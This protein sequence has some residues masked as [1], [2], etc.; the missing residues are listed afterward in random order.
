MIKVIADYIYNHHISKLRKHYEK[1]AQNIT[2]NQQSFI[3]WPV[4]IA[5][6]LSYPAIYS[7]YTSPDSLESS[8]ITDLQNIGIG[9][10]STSLQDPQS[11][12]SN[13][14]S[15]KQLWLAPKSFDLYQNG[16]DIQSGALNKNFLLDALSLQNELLD[17]INQNEDSFAFI[18]SPF[19]YWDNDLQLLKSDKSPIRILQKGTVKM[20]S[21]GVSLSHNGLFSGV[22]KVNGLIKSAEAI[23][24]LIFYESRKHNERDAGKIWDS[25]LLK[26]KENST[27][28]NFLISNEG[29]NDHS[30]KTFLL[31]LTKMNS[32]DHFVL[33]TSYVLIGVYF[34]VSLSNL[35]S[36]RSR[37]GLLSAFV[38]ELTLAV[39][40][41][42]TLTTY[43]FQGVDFYQIP[44]QFLPFV[45]IVVGIE[46]MF[47]LV[48]TLS[49]TPGELSISYR[50]SKALSDCG[51]TSTL[52]VLCD[53]AI[54]AVIYP[55][56]VPNTKQFCIFASFALII[57]HT[58]HLTYFT[59]VLSIDTH[60]LE[61]DDLLNNDSNFQS[62]DDK[63]WFFSLFNTKRNTNLVASLTDDQCNVSFTSVKA[64][65]K[66]VIM[67]I[68]LPFSTTVTGTIVMILFLIGT[69]IRWTD[70]SLKFPLVGHPQSYIGTHPSP[71]SNEFSSHIQ[72]YAETQYDLL[73]FLDKKSFS[74]EIFKLLEKSNQ[75]DFSKV[76]ISVYNPTVALHGASNDPETSFQIPFNLNTTYKFDLYYILEFLT[77]LAFIL[78][79]ALMVLRSFAPESTTEP[80]EETKKQVAEKDHT[81]QSKILSGGHFLDI[82][83]I[84]TSRSPFIVSVGLDHKVLVWSPVSQPMPIP[85]QLPIGS[86]IWPITHVVLSDHGSYISVFSKSGAIQCYSRL[87]MTWIWKVEIE[88]L[89][90]SLPLEAFFRRK[91]IPAFLQ[92]KMAT[93]LMQG[94]RSTPSSRRNSMRS[95]ASPNLGP[96]MAFSNNSGLSKDLKELVIV[97][98]NGLIA[99]VSCEDGSLKT[100]KLSAS[101]LVSSAKLITP[102]VN[103]RLVSCTEDGKLMLSTAVNNKWKT[104]IVKVDEKKFNNPEAFLA[105][106][107]IQT[108][109]T[110]EN[111]QTYEEKVRLNLEFSKSTIAIVP[112][113]GF[114]VRTHGSCAEIIDVQTGILIK[115]FQIRQF[116][117]NT[118]KVFHDQPTHCRFCGSVSISSFTVVYTTESSSVNM[119]TFNVDHRA[120][121][122]ICLRVE[123]DPREI[124]CV[125]FDSVTEHVHELS[126]TEGWSTTDKNQIVGIRRKTE[127]EVKQSLDE[128]RMSTL[129]RRRSPY[130]QSHSDENVPRLHNLWEGWAMSADGNIEYYDIP[131]VGNSGGLLVNSIGQINRFG[132]KSI[133]V[134]FGNIMQVLYLGNDDLIYNDE[135]KGTNNEISGLSFINKRR[136]N[137][138]RA[139][140]LTST[141]FS[142]VDNIPGIS[143]LA[144]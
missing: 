4:S 27:D 61:L 137:M 68:K 40:S 106:T 31:K 56:V 28:I 73:C 12:D 81:F 32:I 85:S 5:F 135:D 116:K 45:V 59:A 82:I 1:L 139:D 18:H 143:E 129:R 11:I 53:L 43:F 102:R 51:I 90:N 54:L 67:R 133:V 124:R 65:L 99:T 52:I 77:S 48:T 120:K 44:L 20:N 47:R 22:V 93:A 29:P 57:D 83:K 107:N 128:A 10:Q 36:V 60:R 86:N 119:H 46:N 70:D 8:Y 140:N 7:L 17:G 50:I 114:I 14:L 97:L 131:D 109:P 39:L 104:R 35:K 108:L 23:R 74:T 92:R 132:H 6:I 15:L 78:S 127:D 58:L 111:E 136:K 9:I 141:N 125:G 91:S 13:S 95:I 34:I 24:I 96:K 144:L 134:A 88:E 69:N 19:Q 89:R 100:E 62:S 79:I 138:R 113:V 3:I 63:R 142:E 26:I 110:F 16:Y 30:V 87:T 94:I 80:E 130:H 49:E 122:R 103:D 112:F 126:N 75:K 64:K 33:T 37:I 84:T 105:K 2:K 98:K 117:K 115:R 55:I 25:N 101:P 21:S 123:R 38:V 71:S 118:L 42:A 72:S 66:D 76:L 41:S 121:T